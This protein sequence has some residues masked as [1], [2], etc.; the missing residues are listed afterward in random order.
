MLR[1][2]RETINGSW[3]LSPLTDLRETDTG[4]VN[5]VIVMRPNVP[6]QRR[7]DAVRCTRLLGRAALAIA[8]APTDG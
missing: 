6:V 2:G 1:V 7:R 8:N 3:N 4:A 5:V